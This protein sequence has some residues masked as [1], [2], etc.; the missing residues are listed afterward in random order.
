MSF[1]NEFIERLCSIKEMREE[2]DKADSKKI[3]MRNKVV[4]LIEA[5]NADEIT[6][7][8]I[9]RLSFT[10]IPEGFPG[11]RP[12]VWKLLLGSLPLK[13]ADWRTQIEENF[14]TY[15]EFKKELIVK[16]QLKD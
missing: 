6:L 5:I 4:Q 1:K 16:P 7:E 2:Y 11:L 3:I 9:Q 13:T 14:K 12:I 8:D 15:E 10:G